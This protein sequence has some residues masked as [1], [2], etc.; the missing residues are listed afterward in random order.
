MY[1]LSINHNLDND[2]AGVLEVGDG[3]ILPKLIEI[4]LDFAIIH[5][6]ALGWDEQGNFSNTAFPYGQDMAGSESGN[7]LSNAQKQ[8]MQAGV[9]N[10]IEEAKKALNFKKAIIGILISL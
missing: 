6:H 4:A 8:I 3:V 9:Y 1:N 10:A 7:A 2:E 5:E